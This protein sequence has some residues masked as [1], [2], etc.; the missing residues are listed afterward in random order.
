ML[1]S[2]N[3]L[4]TAEG[5]YDQVTYPAT[6]GFGAAVAD[7]SFVKAKSRKPDIEFE[8]EEFLDS[9]LRQVEP[10]ANTSFID[11]DN[12]ARSLSI[13]GGN[14]PSLGAVWFKDT[15]SIG[16]RNRFCQDNGIWW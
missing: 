9:K 2:R 6:A 11:V 10:A 14:G 16:G 13:G 4:V 1:T 7:R 3:H 8:Q 12:A 5:K 15:R